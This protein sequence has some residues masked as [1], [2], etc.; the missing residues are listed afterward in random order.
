MLE[1]FIFS[2]AI[3]ILMA[4]ALWIKIF[5]NR[6]VEY[7]EDDN[8]ANFGSGVRCKGCIHVVNPEHIKN[9]A[10]CAKREDG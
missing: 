3:V 9:F 10:P 7:S 2:F 1:I 5:I 6:G 4:G 8:H